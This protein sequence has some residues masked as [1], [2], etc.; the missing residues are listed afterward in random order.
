MRLCC[1][2]ALT[3]LLAGCTDAD[4]AGIVPTSS[5]SSGLDAAPVSAAMAIPTGISDKVAD[6]CQAVAKARSGDAALQDFDE[7]VQQAVYDKTYAD[8][9]IWA[10]KTMR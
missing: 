9:M 5:P 3:L 10:Q 7:S 4:W 8:C 6:K 2:V 1:V